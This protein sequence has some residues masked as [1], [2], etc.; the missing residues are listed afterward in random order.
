MRSEWSDAII[1]PDKVEL[2]VQIYSKWIERDVILVCSLLRI[3]EVPNWISKRH[4]VQ[5]FIQR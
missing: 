2:C 5:C 1:D 4:Y 3:V